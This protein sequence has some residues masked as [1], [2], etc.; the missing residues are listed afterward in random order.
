MVGA[1]ATAGVVVGGPI[2]LG[3]APALLVAML[4]LLW[5]GSG[6]AAIDRRLVNSG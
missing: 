5:A 4:Y 6:P 1:I 2:H 3:L